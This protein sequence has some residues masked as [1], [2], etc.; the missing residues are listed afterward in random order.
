MRE[1]EEGE[2]GD[3]EGIPR[4]SRIERRDEDGY[5]VGRL[6]VEILK[7]EDGRRGGKLRFK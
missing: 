4:M 2:G 3:P 6:E 7:V 5:R 1:G